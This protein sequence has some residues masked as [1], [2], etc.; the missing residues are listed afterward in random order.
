MSKTPRGYSKTVVDAV[1]GASSDSLGVTLG[2][3]CIQKD[4]PV[5][6]IAK[7]FGV[8]RQAVYWWFKGKIKPSTKHTEKMEKLIEKLS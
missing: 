8:S 5:N 4:I 6:D 7:F 3:I 2:R 1:E